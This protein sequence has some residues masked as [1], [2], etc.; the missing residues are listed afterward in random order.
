MLLPSRGSVLLVTIFTFLVFL[1]IMI[2]SVR[3]INRQFRAT[4]NTEGKTASFRLADAGV[5]Y[6][7]FLLGSGTKSVPALVNEEQ[8]LERTVVDPFS[9]E[10]AGTFSLT[11]EADSGAPTEAVTVTSVGRSALGGNPCY[12]ITADVARASG[13]TIYQIVAWSST[14]S[15]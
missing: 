11:F 8:P 5:D 6:T 10:P 14:A 1:T 7:I 2:A 3:F 4:V 9:D 12:T 13:T 15:C